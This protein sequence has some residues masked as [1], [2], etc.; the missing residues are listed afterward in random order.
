M[1]GHNHHHDTALFHPHGHQ[2]DLD[3]GHDHHDDDLANS[4]HLLKGSEKRRLMA[5]A[6]MTAV[7]MVME[8]AGGFFTNS[9]ALVSDAGHMLTHLLALTISF[10]AIIFAMRPPTEEKSFGFH[11]LEILA[12]LFNGVTLLLITAWIIYSAYIRFYNPRSIAG[13]EMFTIALAGLI[14]NIATTY[15]LS[16]SEGG[17]INIRS[18]FLHMIGDTLSS[19]GV[20]A[21]A[22]I[23]YYTG[24]VIIDPILSI[25]LSIAI[26]IWSYQL[27]RESINI[28]LEATP[29]DID[30]DELSESVK[31]IEE[32]KDIHDLHVWT[33]TSNMYALSAHL[34]IKNM[35][36]S[37][38]M[39]LLRRIN[40]LLC[41]KYR[42]GHTAIQFECDRVERY[43]FHHTHQKI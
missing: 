11:R 9:L 26:L 34:S 6:G 29:K 41:Q 33:L 23:I 24:W 4:V 17:G 16:S 15:I 5:A 12:A 10:L 31:A 19:V 37:D 32:V 35:H 40:F 18:A 20:V 22:L 8:V 21:A 36:I 43:P 2:C 14:V 38:T 25:L 13:L 30:L 1:A 39:H 27:I 3:F 28:L 7:M 42:I